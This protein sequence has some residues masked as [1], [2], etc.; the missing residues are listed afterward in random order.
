MLRPQSMNN[1]AENFPEIFQKFREYL[2][3]SIM[4][5]AQ[6]TKKFLEFWDNNF[7]GK[8]GIKIFSKN[9]PG[10]YFVEICVAKY[11]LEIF[12]KFSRNFLE[13]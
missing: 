13:I 7:V 1:F 10:I 12:Q 9:F 3:Q 2:W 5:R 4:G 11:F 8:L 6:S